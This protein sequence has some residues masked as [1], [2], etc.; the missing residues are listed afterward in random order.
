[1][2]VMLS[3]MKLEPLSIREQ[4]LRR[5]LWWSVVLVTLVGFVLTTT[6]WVALSD[7]KRGTGAFDFG[8]ASEAVASYPMRLN[9]LV[10]GNDK[11][12]VGELVY[13]TDVLLKP[14]PTPKLFF[15]AGSHGTEIMTVAEG[16]HVVAAPGDMVDVRGTIRNTPSVTALRKQ[17]KL[18]LGDARRISDIPIYIESDFIRDSGG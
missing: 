9:T 8:R 11:A 5:V 4:K 17:W 12:T 6:V 14:G 3:G 10:T 1:M 18:S 16:A 15:L 2:E 7:W 13:L